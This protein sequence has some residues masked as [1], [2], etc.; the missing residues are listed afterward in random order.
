MQVRRGIVDIVLKGQK[1][2]AKFEKKSKKVERQR[3][4]PFVCYPIALE[5]HPGPTP[6]D[7]PRSGLSWLDVR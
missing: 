1:A 5:N 2:V 3:T 7:S 6:K 4:T